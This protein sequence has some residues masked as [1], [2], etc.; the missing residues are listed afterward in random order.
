MK[1]SKVKLYFV[2]LK[3]ENEQLSDNLHKTQIELEG[4]KVE[5]DVL[6]STL[7]EIK[8]SGDYEERNDLSKEALDALGSI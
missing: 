4:K 3:K 2:C 5:L 1:E 7:K 8:R 6:K